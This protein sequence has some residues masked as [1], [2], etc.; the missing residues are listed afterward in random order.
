MNLRK[1]LLFLLI[2]AILI[3]GGPRQTIA[4]IK[5]MLQPLA[6]RLP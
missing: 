5:R 1:L 3:L 6:Q 2:A 4:T